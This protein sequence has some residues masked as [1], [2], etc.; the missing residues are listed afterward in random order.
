M[1]LKGRLDRLE[2]RQPAPDADRLPPHFWDI[3]FG[4]VDPEILDAN[5]REELRRFLEEGEAEHA[6][7]M[8]KHP[9]GRLYREEL[10]RL[11]LPQPPTLADIDVIEESIRLAS[12]P[13]LDPS[14][15]GRL[16]GANGQRPE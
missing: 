8:E 1:S 12:I 6:R 13:A 7:C 15:N 4:V 11:G 16:N 5:E 14:T 2:R 3:L 9:A 10:D